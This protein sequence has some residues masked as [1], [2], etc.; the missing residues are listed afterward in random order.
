MHGL[1]WQ[2]ED[3]AGW[4][5]SEKLDGWR[6]YWDGSNFMTRQGK[7]YA[8]PEWFKD[9]M[10]DTPLD[11]ELW[12]GPGTNHDDVNRAL[13]S[14]GWAGLMFRPFD[15]PVE[16][17]I[18][19]A[20]LQVLQSLPLPAHASP[21]EYR[22][23]ESTEEAKNIMLGIVHVGGE[24]IMLRSPGSKYKT[25]SRSYDLLKMKGLTHSPA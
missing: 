1:D 10:P 16:G 8:A 3:V 13:H 5:L 18:I 17:T 4:W 15:I 23:V 22:R 2:G 11:G 21:V 7:P 20:A 6:A 9:G 19:E 12:A 14:G 24:G 25:A